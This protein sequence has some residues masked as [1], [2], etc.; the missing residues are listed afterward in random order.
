MA[1]ANPSMTFHPDNTQYM[2]GNA[3]SNSSFYFQICQIIHPHHYLPFP[4]PMPI[5]FQFYDANQKCCDS[6]PSILA[7]HSPTLSCWLSPGECYRPAVALTAHGAVPSIHFR[8]IFGL[9]RLECIPANAKVGEQ[10]ISS[11][12]LFLCKLHR[13]RD[14]VIICHPRNCQMPA[15]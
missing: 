7:I 1:L 9:L 15:V 8:C 6:A 3:H 5:R 13:L 11:Y 4:M 10:S 14:G 12:P 2:C